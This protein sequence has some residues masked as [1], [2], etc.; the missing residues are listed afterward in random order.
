M[1]CHVYYLAPFKNVFKD[2]LVLATL[3]FEV[4]DKLWP[5]KLLAKLNSSF[6]IE[7][8]RFCMSIGV[9]SETLVVLLQQS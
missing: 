8:F 4:G 3:V 9:L 2:F 1:L 6:S 7:D 5:F